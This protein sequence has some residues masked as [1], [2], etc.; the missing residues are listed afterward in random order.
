MKYI[1]L[2]EAGSKSETSKN[3]IFE[4]D[5]IFFNNKSVSVIE[6]CGYTIDE[7]IHFCKEIEESRDYHLKLDMLRTKNGRSRYSDLH[8][9][10]KILTITTID[11]ENIVLLYKKIKI[12][13]ERNEDLMDYL[14]EIEDIGSTIK[15]EDDVL[16][17]RIKFSDIGYLTKNLDLLNKIMMRWNIKLESRNINPYIE[18]ND[19]YDMSE[20]SDQTMTISYYLDPL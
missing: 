7:F 13:A 17:I 9:L 20:S 6:D 3:F 10:E 4:R 15:I 8:K 19:Y 12:I 14:L 18:M 16:R 11:V 2:F 5:G 1:K